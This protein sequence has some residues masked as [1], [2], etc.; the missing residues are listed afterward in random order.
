MKYINF[1]WALYVIFYT[2]S[3]VNPYVFMHRMGKISLLEC[4]VRKGGSHVRTGLVFL[5][6]IADK[7]KREFWKEEISPYKIMPKTM[8]GTGFNIP[9]NSDALT[10]SLIREGGGEQ[11]LQWCH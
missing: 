11:P 9:I 8:V 4:E 6:S 3:M 5:I 7:I 10:F 1:N 2:L